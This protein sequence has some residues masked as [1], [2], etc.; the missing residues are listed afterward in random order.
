MTTLTAGE[1]A[2]NLDHLAEA[3]RE[4][5][6]DEMEVA[7]EY[8]IDTLNEMCPAVTS[9]TMSDSDQGDH[10]WFD[11]V[12]CAAHTREACPAQALID[13][14]PYAEYAYH[15]YASQ[16]NWLVETY[17]LVL[18][19]RHSAGSYTLDIVTYSARHLEHSTGE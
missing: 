19:H 4:A 15:L 10:L 3:T 7:L 8:A 1:R 14:D 17:G 13:S 11:E 9:I 16:V 5:T 2:C 6:L 12:T 18:A